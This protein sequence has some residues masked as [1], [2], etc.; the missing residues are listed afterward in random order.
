[1]LGFAHPLR[2]RFPS[3]AHNL[4]YVHVAVFCC[5]RK[6]QGLGG[7]GTNALVARAAK[8]LLAAARQHAVLAATAKAADAE[9]GGT[10]VGGA[11]V[12]S[13]TTHI[14]PAIASVVKVPSSAFV[15][16]LQLCSGSANCMSCVHLL[17]DHHLKG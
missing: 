11:A 15:S 2:F 5:T 10:Q 14:G 6:Q 17:L 8:S 4:S 1:M 3:A 13:G 12:V 16:L 7:Y 9:L